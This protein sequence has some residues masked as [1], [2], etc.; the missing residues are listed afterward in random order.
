MDADLLIAKESN[1]EAEAMSDSDGTGTAAGVGA[2][3]DYGDGDSHESVDNQLEAI[4]SD[5]ENTDDDEE[6]EDFMPYQFNRSAERISSYI[7]NRPR[8]SVRH[9]P[10]SIS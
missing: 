6:V 10:T 1:S 7:K 2:D 8:T 9:H 3:P 5:G 4:R